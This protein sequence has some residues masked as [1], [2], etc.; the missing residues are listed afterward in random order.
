[1]N[2]MIHHNVFLMSDMKYLDSLNFSSTK[3]RTLPYTQ[4]IFYIFTA[5]LLHTFNIKNIF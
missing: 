2:L 4:R 5:K 1:M 3:F